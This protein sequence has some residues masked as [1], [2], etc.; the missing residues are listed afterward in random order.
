MASSVGGFESDISKNGQTHEH[1][2][3]AYKLSVKQL[4]VA[5]NKMDIM[6][7]PYS[8][9]RFKEINKEG[10]AYIKKI[11][12]NSEAVTFVPISGWYGDNMIEPSTKVR[13]DWDGINQMQPSQIFECL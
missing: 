4:I 7:P 8:S 1:V 3:L 11:G 9:T 6:E 13:T 5:V 2:L 10:N 12:Y